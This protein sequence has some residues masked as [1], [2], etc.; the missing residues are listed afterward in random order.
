MGCNP[1]PSWRGTNQEDRGDSVAGVPSQVGQ[2]G[3]KGA[4]RGLG[5]QFGPC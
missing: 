4:R 3:N 5:L 2:L 1:P